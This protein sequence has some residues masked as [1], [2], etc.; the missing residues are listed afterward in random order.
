MAHGKE[1]DRLLARVDAPQ[2]GIF[3]LLRPD[4]PPMIDLSH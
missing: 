2:L 4:I 3:R 1:A